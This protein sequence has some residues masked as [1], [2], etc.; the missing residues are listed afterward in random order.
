[1]LAVIICAGHRRYASVGAVAA[2]PAGGA[3]QDVL[4]DREAGGQEAEAEEGGERQCD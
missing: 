2:A 3:V 4:R 1:M